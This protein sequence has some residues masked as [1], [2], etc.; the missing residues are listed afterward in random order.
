MSMKEHQQTTKT[1]STPLPPPPPAPPPAL[2]GS[3]PKKHL[4]RK[5]VWNFPRNNL[6]DDFGMC[7]SYT[8]GPKVA[9][10]QQLQFSNAKES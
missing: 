10:Q 9:E 5:N 3:K 2:F 7:Q 8:V 6:T 4:K 1:R